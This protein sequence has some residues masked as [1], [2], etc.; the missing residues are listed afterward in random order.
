MG[1]R[2]VG[3]AIGRCFDPFLVRS[4]L[5]GAET[6]APSLRLVVW[7]ALRRR[8]ASA[9]GGYLHVWI[10]DLDQLSRELL[11]CLSVCQPVCVINTVSNHDSITNSLII[12][13]C[14]I[15]T[16]YWGKAPGDKERDVL[17]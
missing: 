3:N 7:G 16:T 8:R 1:L 17:Y 4:R 14:F 10:P 5:H 12:N 9:W 2:P 11:R 13:Q 6:P 15:L